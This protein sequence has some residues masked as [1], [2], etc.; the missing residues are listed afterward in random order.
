M[1]FVLTG[2]SGCGKTM[3]SQR[4]VAALK[5]RGVNVAGV[6]TPP[7]LANDTKIGMEVEDVR[8]GKRYAL[9]ERAAI[10]AGTAHLSWKFDANGIVCG[11][12]IL[13]DALPC[14]VLVVDELGPL[15]LIHDEG[16]IVALEVLQAKKYRAALVVVRPSLLENFRARLKLEM[17]V[18]TV[19]RSNREELFNQITEMLDPRIAVNP[20]ESK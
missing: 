6:V 19:T 13:R 17:Q 18:L 5:A 7:R 4:V 8:T 14:D 15:E 3:L 12:Q 2:E 1:I 9:A 11:A 10:G 20:R 16:W